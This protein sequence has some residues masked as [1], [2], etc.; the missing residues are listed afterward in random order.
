MKF[1]SEE[2]FCESE[3][4]LSTSSNFVSVQSKKIRNFIMYVFLVVFVRIIS[5]DCQFKKKKNP[6]CYLEMKTF[7]FPQSQ[8]HSAIICQSFSVAYFI[9]ASCI[10]LFSLIAF[11]FVSKLSV[12]QKL[13][14]QALKALFSCLVD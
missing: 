8:I 5:K 14:K 7:N 4:H 13:N 10:T 2:T 3:I 11:T 1:V 6:T 9:S 12:L